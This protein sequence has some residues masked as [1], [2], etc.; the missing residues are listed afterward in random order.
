MRIFL[1]GLPGCGKSTVAQ[2]LAEKLNYKFIDMDQAIIARVGK[3]ISDIFKDDGETYFRDIE[4]KVL[5]DLNEV[6]N[7]VIACGG[8]IC[9]YNPRNLFKG[10]VI[11]L[12]V[13]VSILE[14]RLRNDDTRPLLKSNSV[15]QLA[16]KRNNTY[17]TYSDITID[18]YDID[19]T[20]D[21]LIDKIKEY[22]NYC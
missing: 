1:I 5:A 18:N 19:E 8:G 14:E 11:F 12:K 22:I 4:S 2:I 7:I 6:D 20:I 21:T 17:E 3:S 16:Q 15:Y 10:L 9:E 13:D